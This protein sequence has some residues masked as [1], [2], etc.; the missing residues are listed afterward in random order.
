MKDN[1][2]NINVFNTPAGG[3]S[4]VH[5]RTTLVA[6]SHVI[7]ERLEGDKLITMKRFEIGDMAEY[8]SFNLS[9][10]GPIVAIGNKTI[11]IRASKYSD[12]ESHTR[13][14]A[15]TFAWRNW[16]FDQNRVASKN[17]NTMTFI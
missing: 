7:V 5:Y 16:N 11:S 4:K 1:N 3:P 8:D 2:K 10:Y 14:K 13:L 9:Y 12:C 15:D 6:K 17:S